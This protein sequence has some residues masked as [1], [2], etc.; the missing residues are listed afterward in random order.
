[1][2]V[3]LY[4]NR[5]AYPV[6]YF[7]IDKLSECDIVV[8]IPCFDEPDLIKTLTSVAQTIIPD[9]CKIGV[10]VVINH[11]Q[12]DDEKLKQRN[13]ST[14]KH[15]EAWIN[16]TEIDGLYFQS[17]LIELPHKHAGVGLARKVG[18][19]DAVRAFNLSNK[20]GAIVC[21]DADCTV[22]QSYFQAIWTAFDDN[23]VNAA[24]LYFEHDIDVNHSNSQPSGI[25]LYELYLRYYIDA[26]RYSGYPR[27]VQTI[28]SS[29]AVRCSAY[30][31]CGGMNRRKAGEDFYFIHKL[32]PFGGYIEINETRVIPS[33]RVSDRVPFGTGAAIGK[34][35]KEPSSLETI[36]N[37]LIFEEFKIFL[38][39]VHKFFQLSET[40][41]KDVIDSLPSSIQQ[42]L[43]IENGLN[44]IIELKSR[45]NNHQAFFK[46]FLSYMDGLQVLKY[47]HYASEYHFPKIPLKE[48]IDWLFDHYLGQESASSLVEALVAIRTY[49]RS[50]TI[51]TGL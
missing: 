20:D 38:E 45:T 43:I 1:M 6:S 32:L 33:G 47:V 41:L 10:I 5:Y 44:T 25:V 28:G 4:L 9:T 31:K 3:N 36:Y 13:I 16:I 50:S 37:P 39:S 14:Q 12:N 30:Q 22:D 34:W 15:C 29:M 19:D 46:Q 49:D 51:R 11:G 40:E 24:S 35:T 26:L 8:V 27:A 17:A 18:M 42:F 48:G 7:N 2:K 23:R 21:L